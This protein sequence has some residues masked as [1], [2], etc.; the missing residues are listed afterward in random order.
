MLFQLVHLVL[1]ETGQVTGRKE[2]QPLFQLREDAMA[3]AEFETARIGDEY[4]YDADQ[5]C[6]WAR[7]GAQLVLLVV[8]PVPEKRA[9]EMGQPCWAKQVNATGPTE[10]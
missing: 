7:D 5:D 6:W 2:T 10:R 9:A 3:L 4:G 8:E 1:N